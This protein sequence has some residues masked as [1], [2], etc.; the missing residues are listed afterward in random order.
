T[1]A[2][3]VAVRVHDAVAGADDSLGINLIGE[4]DARP[5]VLV[6]VMDRRAAVAG[7]WS[8]TR[9]LQRSVNTGN[10][11]RQCGDKEAHIVVHFAKRREVVV[12]KAK[13]ERQLRRDL[14][15]VLDV[16]RDGTET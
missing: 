6:V 13:I 11:V 14:P 8:L 3:S 15:I 5:N 7:V 1:T 16:R 2:D 10:R 9:K 4:T 12:A